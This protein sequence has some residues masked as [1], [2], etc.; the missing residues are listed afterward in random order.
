MAQTLRHSYCDKKAEMGHKCVGVVT[1]KPGIVELSCA[2]CGS[3]SCIPAFS[4]TSMSQCKDVFEAAGID[5]HSLTVEAQHRAAK[6]LEGKR[7]T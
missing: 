3:G 4:P 5:F 1:I 7:G 6:A 2:L